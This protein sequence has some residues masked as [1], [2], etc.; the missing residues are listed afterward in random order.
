MR[1]LL[2]FFVV[3]LVALFSLPATAS[4][5]SDVKAAYAAWDAAFSKGDAKAVAAF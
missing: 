5:E 4:P 3:A 1:S 2:S